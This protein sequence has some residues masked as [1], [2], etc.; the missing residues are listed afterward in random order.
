MREIFDVLACRPAT[1]EVARDEGADDA[2]LRDELGRREAPWRE[3]PV[4]NDDREKENDELSE[5]KRYCV[6]R[7]TATP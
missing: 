4:V 7:H 6:R 5:G 2:C 3:A 1:S